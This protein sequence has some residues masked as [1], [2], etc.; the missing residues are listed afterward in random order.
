MVQ[1]HREGLCRAYPALRT[2]MAA[3][4]RRLEIEVEHEGDD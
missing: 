3:Y 4:G 1:G 2:Y